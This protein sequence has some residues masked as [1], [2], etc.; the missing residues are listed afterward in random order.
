[1]MRSL[2]LSRR[3]A[4][5]DSSTIFETF[6]YP[7]SPRDWL[8]PPVI[9]SGVNATPASRIRSVNARPTPGYPPIGRGLRAVGRAAAKEIEADGDDGNRSIGSGSSDRDFPSVDRSA[10][11][12]EGGQWHNNQKL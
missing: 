9:V 6:Q 3:A 1:M 11:I 2:P 7:F 4:S 8:P 12:I 5:S 10:K